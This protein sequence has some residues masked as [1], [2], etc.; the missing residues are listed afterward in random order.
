VP[1]IEW[2]YIG[3]ERRS[4]TYQRNR[5]LDRCQ[6]DIVFFLDDD[7]F[8]YRD[9]AEMILRVYES[10]LR[11]EIGGVSAALAACRESQVPQ[12]T[13]R[14]P[15]RPNE[16][17]PWARVLTSLWDQEQLFLPYDGA[18]HVRR[19]S[20]E[21]RQ[22]GLVPVALFHGCRM[23]FRI[24]AARAAGGFDEVLIRTA[25]GEDCDF[26]YRISR[27]QSLVLAPSALLFHEQ[28]PAARPKRR[29]N[30]TLI[31]LNAVA[32]Y[33]LHAPPAW[34]RKSHILRFLSKRLALETLRDGMRG[35]L[36][37]P[38]IRGALRALRYAPGLLALD[39]EQL[40]EEYPKLQTQLCEAG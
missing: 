30:T 15:N 21:Q 26:S 29:L 7:S 12:V 38:C 6:G 3:S 13:N 11:Q 8:M 28:T 10:D 35:R 17:R 32:L 22:Q 40:R 36:A 14:R 24:N 9:C 23:T 4:S 34:Q 33:R 31:L 1:G 16:A 19:L 2:I 39:S 5:G 18:F 25:F 37:A 27:T 20:D